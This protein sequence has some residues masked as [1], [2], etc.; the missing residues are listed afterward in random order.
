MLIY[1]HR[2]IYLYTKRTLISAEQIYY[3]HVYVLTFQVKD[4][5]HAQD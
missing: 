5:A 4:S 2:S 3:A 1:E